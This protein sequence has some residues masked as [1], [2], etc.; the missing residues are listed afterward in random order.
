MRE[1]KFRAWHEGQKIM[2]YPENHIIELYSDG[3]FRVYSQDD[4]GRKGDLVMNDKHGFLMEYTGLE[5][6]YDTEICEGDLIN[7]GGLKP[8]VIAFE[9]YKWKAKYKNYKFSDTLNFTQEGM[10]TFG[11]VMGNIWEHKHLL[12]K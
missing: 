8:L 2:L 4:N 1:H 5:D 12:D 11:E 6:M 9:D 7:F 3:M 10:S